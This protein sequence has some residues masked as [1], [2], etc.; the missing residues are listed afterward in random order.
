LTPLHLLP[1]EIMNCS[2]ILYKLY[3]SLNGKTLKYS[4]GV[5]PKVR[6]SFGPLSLSVKLISYEGYTL[7]NLCFDQQVNFLVRT[8]FYQS[9]NIAKLRSV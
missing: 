9:R 8:S 5:F 2:F 7:H 1:H 6:E 4:A 3:K